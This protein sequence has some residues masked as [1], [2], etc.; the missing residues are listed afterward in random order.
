[1]YHRKHGCFTCIHV[2]I[3]IQSTH[4]HTHDEFME[5]KHTL[6][7]VCLVFEIT[8]CVHKKGSTLIP[9]TKL[10][11]NRMKCSSYTWVV[12]R[13][14]FSISNLFFD[15]I[16][17]QRGRR[18][19]AIKVF[20]CLTCHFLLL[21]FK[22]FDFV[23]PNANICRWFSRLLCQFKLHSFWLYHI[24]FIPLLANRALYYMKNENNRNEMK[25][26]KEMM[27]GLNENWNCLWRLK[28]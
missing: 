22:L 19:S 16:T 4:A 21:L 18:D 2:F 26:G 20:H 6:I 8:V 10:L 15:V 28:I 24:I 11:W 7:K 3:Y 23:K 14:F 5:L 17:C 27:S 25:K 12:M 13:F 1:M 9:N